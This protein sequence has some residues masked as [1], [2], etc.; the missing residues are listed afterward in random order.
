[1]SSFR[2]QQIVN[3]KPTEE[4]KQL[5]TTAYRVFG[6]RRR[7]QLHVIRAMSRAAARGAGIA[8]QN[9][10]SGKAGLRRRTGGLARNIVGKAY[11]INGNP[12]AAIGVYQKE[13]VPRARTQNYGTRKYNP[14]SPVDTIRP[15]R[16]RLLTIPTDDGGVLTP[17]GVAR[18]GSAREYP[19]GLVYVP[20]LSV[21][22]V[23][24]RTLHGVAALYDKGDYRRAQAANRAVLSARAAGGKVKRRTQRVY[25]KLFAAGLKPA[26]LLFYKVDI[27]PTRFLQKAFEAMLPLIDKE[28][29]REIGMFL[30]AK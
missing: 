3:I 11:E 10:L 1:M 5:L 15:V 18:Y 30:R 2:E 7:F 20:G 6:D 25:D 24:G 12:A 21:G 22:K 9:V 8:V 17:A 26:Y 27:R 29:Q 23:N 16:A 14:K 19:G 28:L 13:V 4:T